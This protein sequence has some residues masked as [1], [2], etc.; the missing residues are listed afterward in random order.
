MNLFNEEQRFRKR[1]M[2]LLLICIDGILY[3]VFFYT[4][5]H[6]ESTKSPISA[7]VLIGFSFIPIL[8]TMFVLMLNLKTTM[9]KTGVEVT[10]FPFLKKTYKWVDVSK[11]Y[12]RKYKPIKEYGGWGIRFSFK[13]GRAFNVSGN[14]GVQLEFKNGKKLLI[15]TQKPDEIT[16]FLL[17]LKNKIS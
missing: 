15:G 17:Q 11:A 12:I 14:I 1:W 5:F 9:N 16:Q 7:G 6:R 2:I 3:S 8:I 4:Y 10:F 13:S